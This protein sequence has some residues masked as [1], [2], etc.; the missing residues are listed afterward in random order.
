MN[1]RRRIRRVGR[2]AYWALFL[3][4]SVVAATWQLGCGWQRGQTYSFGTS[5]QEAA[6]RD[7]GAALE[8]QFARTGHSKL[9]QVETKGSID[10]LV[11]LQ[12][13]TLDFGVVQGGLE[14]DPTG[15]QSVAAVGYEY[16]HI[17]VPASSKV[18]Q[19]KDLAG[20]R[21]AAGF[22]GSGSRSVADRLEEVSSLEPPMNLI[23]VPRDSIGAALAE[24]RVDAAM[25]VTGLR[26]ELTPMLQTGQYRL[27]EIPQAEALALQLF[28]VE[29]TSIPAG[30]YGENLSIPPEPLTT[31]MVDTNILVRDDVP[32]STV[33]RLLEVLFTPNVRRRAHLPNL[34]EE[35]ARVEADLDLH[36]A[37]MNYYKRNDPLT[38]V[39]LEIAGFI[40]AALLAA[41]GGLRALYEWWKIRQQKVE[42]QMVQE[43]LRKLQKGTVSLPPHKPGAVLCEAQQ[44][45]IEG[46]IGDEDLRLILEVVL[47]QSAVAPPREEKMEPE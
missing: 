17:V 5:N 16:L 10:N 11:G 25:Y 8:D 19:F 32:G 38:S 20:K 2:R 36:P 42:R 3:L 33:R 9:K 45:W 14:F 23:S 44:R 18:R 37:A 31:L 4:L 43:F 28:D 21:V 40:L 13:G 6:D 29:T 39:E 34:T 15:L 46:R 35:L 24:G 22:E 7:L 1:E 47:A 26:R 41:I 12:D 30:I 27:V